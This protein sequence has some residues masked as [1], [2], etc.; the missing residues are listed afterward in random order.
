ME[1]FKL[2]S[3][4]GGAYYWERTRWLG[5][6]RCERVIDVIPPGVA[7]KC[8]LLGDGF[9]FCPFFLGDVA[10]IFFNFLFSLYPPSYLYFRNCLT[11]FSLLFAFMCLCASFLNCV[12]P[13]LSLKSFGILYLCTS[14]KLEKLLRFSLTILYFCFCRGFIDPM[15]MIRFTDYSR[16]NNR[17]S[18]DRLISQRDLTLVVAMIML[19]SRSEWRQD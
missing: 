4:L 19:W 15:E 11:A 16:S 8:R 10:Y 1:W 18:E 9:L 3:Q 7:G 6:P 13:V 17:E 12:K 14:S 5:F 2:I